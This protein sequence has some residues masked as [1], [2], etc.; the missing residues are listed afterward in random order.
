MNTSIAYFR[1]IAFALLWII[2]VTVVFTLI[3][4]IA[5]LVAGFI[6][7]LVAFAAYSA[8]CDL[9]LIRLLGTTRPV[10]DPFKNIW[11]HAVRIVELVRPEVGIAAVGSFFHAGTLVVTTGFLSNL[12]ESERNLVFEKALQRV[13]TPQCIVLTFL[14][15][16]LFVFEKMAKR[17]DLKTADFVKTVFLYAPYT[18]LKNLGSSLQWQENGHHL[19]VWSKASLAGCFLEKKI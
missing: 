5:G 6:V 8:V 15:P 10:S 19:K 1:L 13:K 18:T 9:I 7:G 4:G 17:G 3:F 11:P 2:S 14:S 12:Q 16:I